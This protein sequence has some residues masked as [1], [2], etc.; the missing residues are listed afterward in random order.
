MS[1]KASTGSIPLSVPVLAGNEWAYVKECLDTAWVS[2]AGSFVTRFEAAVCELTGAAHAVALVNGTAALHLALLVAGVRP[3][4]L[5][6]VPTLTFIATA[7]AV[8]HAGADPVFVDCDGFMNIDPAG[9]R[10]FL[11][12]ACEPGPDGAPVER[13]S[14]R[15]VRAVVPVHVFGRPA[16]LA[17][18]LPLAEEHGLAVV[19]DATEALG[20]RWTAGPL[21]G[22]AAGAAA[23]G[24]GVYSFNGNKIVTSGGGGMYVTPSAADAA[25]VRHLST[26]AKTDTV[27][28]VHDEAA[29]NYRL[30]NLAAALGVAQLEQLAGFIAA[31]KA[32]HDLYA[33]LLADVPG[34]RLLGAADGTAPNYWFI[35]ALVDPSEFGL[36][37]EGLMQSLR[38]VGIDTRPVWGLLHE[39][40]PYSRCTSWRVEKAWWFWRRV[41]NL[42][43]SSD[44]TPPEVERVVAAI[45]A[46]RKGD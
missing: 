40:A 20:S 30:T 1:E 8:R 23:A 4:D 31:K 26:Q 24:G 7:N 25:R 19:E 16:D 34:V 44:L 36:D 5:V 41:L 13:A 17:A 28:F 46:T 3:G 11:E 12:E 9:V 39:Q 35:S 32:A 6:I 37:R 38:E 18:L 45:R 21:A 29:W 42:P 2:S 14:G 27:R 22:R 10:S 15:V 33:E 43:C